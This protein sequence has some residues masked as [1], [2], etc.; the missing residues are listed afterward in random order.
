MTSQ[1][2]M[3]KLNCSDIRAT[4]QCIL[5]WIIFMW[6]QEFL[7]KEHTRAILI[8]VG[9]FSWLCWVRVRWAAYFNKETNNQKCWGF[10]C[11]FLH[12]H[13]SL[14]W[15]CDLPVNQVG[16]LTSV[17]LHIYYVRPQFQV[18]LSFV[19]RTAGSELKSAQN[20]LYFYFIFG[21][22]YSWFYHVCVHPSIALFINLTY[23]YWVQSLKEGH[24]FSSLCVNMMFVWPLL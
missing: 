2:L 13:T 6:W 10:F 23:L 16:F 14:V 24:L 7:K 4:G 15:E 11:F 19:R 5:C 21:W 12:G 18:L 1:T 22:E 8:Q 17:K 9:A 20:A 3:I